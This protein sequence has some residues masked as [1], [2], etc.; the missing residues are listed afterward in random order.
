MKTIIADHHGLYREGLKSLLVKINTS[1][2]TQEV[3]SVKQL[4]EL[5]CSQ[6][7]IRL[8]FVDLQIIEGSGLDYLKRFKMRWPNVDIALLSSENDVFTAREAISLGASGCLLKTESFFVLEQGIKLIMAGGVYVSE[9]FI[10]EPTKEKARAILDT[11]TPRQ[12]QVLELLSS[13]LSN[14]EIGGLLALAE[15]TVKAHVAALLRSIG[16]KNR[17]QAANWARDSRMI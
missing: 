4:D 12:K 2:Q 15:G 6:S 7:D 8:V 11:L 14:K 9:R 13:G 10:S 16:V 17:T 5:L 1:V 3:D